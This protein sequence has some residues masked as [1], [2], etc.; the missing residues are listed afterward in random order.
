MSQC[1]Y[2]VIH[3][4]ATAQRRQ[5]TIPQDLRKKDINSKESNY[6]T[7]CNRMDREP[8]REHAN[9]YTK[10]LIPPPDRTY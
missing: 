4:I 1:S 8:Q 10:L 5:K 9:A 3:G 6:F 2:F 7:M